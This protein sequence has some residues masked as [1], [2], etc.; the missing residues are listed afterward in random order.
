MNSKLKLVI[1][2]IIGLIVT[3]IIFVR[4]KITEDN[5]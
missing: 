4:N 5:N 3:V 2:T 1:L